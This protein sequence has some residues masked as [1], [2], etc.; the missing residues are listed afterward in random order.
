MYDLAHIIPRLDLKVFIGNPNVSK[1]IGDTV[2]TIE[3]EDI[4][5][6]YKKAFRNVDLRFKSLK[7]SEIENFVNKL[8]RDLRVVG[9]KI[10]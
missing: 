5:P 10:G 8:V 2:K 1:L 6:L 7:E 3:G 9:N 4:V